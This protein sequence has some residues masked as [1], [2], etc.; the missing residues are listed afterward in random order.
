MWYG[1]DPLFER[2]PDMSP[3]VYCAGN[4]VRYVD[5]T[6]MYFDEANE[7]RAQKI[8]KSLD[9]QISKLE[10]RVAKIERK[11][12]DVGDLNDRI[13]ELRSS[14]SDISDM[15]SNESTEFRYAKASNK[16]NPAGRGL[17]V[18]SATG[19]NDAGHN[20]V[21]MYTG[22]NMGN[23]IHESRHGGQIARG[24]YSFDQ[25]GN[26]TAG[27]GIGSELSAYRAQYSYNGKLNYIDASSA[28]NQQ[29]G[30]SG[31]IP[32]ASTVT[33][34]LTIT[35]DFVRTKIGEVRS[36]VIRGNR[37]HVLV[38]IYINLQ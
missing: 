5:P 28:L 36:S 20:V 17:P 14:K 19:T 18:T 11:G 25:R 32:L 6:G 24:E 38:P 22:G 8:E 10:K 35:P 9:K 21:T 26:P 1:V 33:N 29:F 37:I 15:R 7:K 2:Y 12:G 30:S 23:R 34:I 31:I 3:Y 4:P 13:T 16:N 27:Y